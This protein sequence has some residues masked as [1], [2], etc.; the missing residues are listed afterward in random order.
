MCKFL[1][2]ISRFILLL[3]SVKPTEASILLITAV[4]VSI[5]LLQIHLKVHCKD[6]K[7]S[8]LYGKASTTFLIPFDLHGSTVYRDTTETAAN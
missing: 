1:A 4:L 8:Y 6:F 2:C 3:F 5:I 7:I